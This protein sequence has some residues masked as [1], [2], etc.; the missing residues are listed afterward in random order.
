MIESLHSPQE[1]IALEHQEDAAHYLQH[2]LPIVP[3]V[4]D[5]T[6][7]LA[8]YAIQ[9]RL[10]SGAT[11]W[12]HSFFEPTGDNVTKVN[13]PSPELF[14]EAETYL[15]MQ[16]SLFM[17]LTSIDGR[18]WQGSK[19]EKAITE[20]LREV[21]VGTARDEAGNV[22]TLDVLNCAESDLTAEELQSLENVIAK[23]G[24]YTHGKIF[25][26]LRGIAFFSGSEFPENELGGFQ[27]A[28]GAMRLNIDELRKAAAM[29]P[30]R[31]LRYFRNHPE[32][33]ASEITL[34]HE[35]GHVIDIASEEEVDA[36]FLDKNPERYAWTSFGG[37]TADFSG[38]N[39]IPGWTN[40]VIPRSEYSKANVWRFDEILAIEM[41]GGESPPTS[42]AMTA[43]CEDMAES[44][45]IASLDGDT[46]TIPMRLKRIQEVIDL[47][48]GREMGP[49]TFDV[50]KCE[51]EDGVFRPHKMAAIR[52]G[53]YV[54]S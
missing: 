17:N 4:E 7:V 52:L 5:P 43:P 51:F 29:V 37:R 44:F 13:Q 2:E 26:R 19:S 47:A 45:A 53:V 42:Y 39:S 20:S 24:N 31:Y 54:A 1:R 50:Q 14:G 21:Y 33:S 16:D 30:P 22:R 27:F 10:P 34:A 28:S 25:N 35:F 40:A 8:M 6:N 12:A 3:E 11:Y 9:Q 23:V 15:R 18:W 38:F 32:I 48:E 49:L 46:S 41:A 36:H